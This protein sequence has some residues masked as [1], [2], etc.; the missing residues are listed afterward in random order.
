MQSKDLSVFCDN[1]SVLQ[2]TKNQVFHERTEHSEVKLH[3]IRDILAKGS[4]KV[5]KIPTEENPLI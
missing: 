3:L 1:Q 5:A 4:V 2:L